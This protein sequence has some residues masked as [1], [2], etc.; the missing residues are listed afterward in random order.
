LLFLKTNISEALILPI[1][2]H[3]VGKNWLHLAF[4]LHVVHQPYEAHISVFNLAALPDGS[5]KCD[6]V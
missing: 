5:R 6:G 1:E 4:N 3:E 2:K